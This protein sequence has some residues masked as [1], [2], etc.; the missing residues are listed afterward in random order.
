MDRQAQQRTLYKGDYIVKLLLRR[1][2]RSVSD[3]ASCM[4]DTY[5]ILTSVCIFV[6]ARVRA[7]VVINPTY[8]MH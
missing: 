4:P 5:N 3:D 7:N 6:H 1:L 8:A 2:R